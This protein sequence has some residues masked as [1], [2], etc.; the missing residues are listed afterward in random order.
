MVET[1][2]I[3]AKKFEEKATKALQQKNE[4]ELAMMK[5]KVK[6][7]TAKEAKRIKELELE[8]ENLLLKTNLLKKES[9]NVSLPKKDSPSTSV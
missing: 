6:L 2:D 9:G 5:Q 1:A 7:E 3:E 4:H 8:R